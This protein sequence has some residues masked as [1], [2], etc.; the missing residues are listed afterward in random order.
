[1]PLKINN[2]GN[3]VELFEGLSG[4]TSCLQGDVRREDDAT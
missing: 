4:S 1:M 2:L 3:L